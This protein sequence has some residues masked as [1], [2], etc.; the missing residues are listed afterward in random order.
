MGEIAVS[1]VCNAYNQKKYI[2]SALEGFVMQKTNFLFEVLVH[3]DASTDG[4]QDV[5]REF[6][7]K[8]PDIIKPIYDTENQYSKQNGSLRKIAE[9]RVQGKYI[10]ICEGDDY[11]TDPLKLQKQFDFME[12]H[13]DYTLC[14]CST[15]WLNMLNGTVAKKSR[16]ETDKDVTLEEF[17]LPSNG[18]P[19]PA[20]SFFVKT[21]IWLSLPKWQFPVGDLPLTYYC[22]MK[23]KVRMLADTMCVYR[24]NADGSWTANSSDYEKR[25]KINERMIQ[26]Y[27]NMNED[28]EYKYDALVKKVILKQK[29]TLALMRQDF[30]AITGPELKDMYKSRSFILRLSDRLRCKRPKLYRRLQ[31]V[32]ARNRE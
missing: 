10:A 26:A 16:T 15:D 11:W 7:Q 2:K 27:E 31:V 29:Y 13:P 23:G 4:T 21:D 3:D 32:L 1:V 18:R 12:S 6:E 19:F 5:I 8:Y 30:D 20:V 25:A 22:A 14:G 24:W 17:M 9:R 28:T